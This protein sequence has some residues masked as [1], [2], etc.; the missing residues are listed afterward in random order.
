MGGFARAVAAFERDEDARLFGVDGK[1]LALGLVGRARVDAETSLF[2]P[3]CETMLI[4]Q[5]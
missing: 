5:S 3:L 4:H 2:D 1:V